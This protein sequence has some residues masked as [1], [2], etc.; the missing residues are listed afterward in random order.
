MTI[1]LMRQVGIGL[2]LLFSGYPNQMEWNI[3]GR[4]V[5]KKVIDKNASGIIDFIRL[6]EFWQV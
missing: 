6:E 5:E 3:R 2:A 1:R 4:N